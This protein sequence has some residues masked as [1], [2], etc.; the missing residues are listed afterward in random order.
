MVVALKTVDSLLALAVQ[1][2]ESLSVLTVDLVE[3]S[4][5]LLIDILER[6]QEVL[7]P[8]PVMLLQRLNLSPEHVILTDELLLVESVLIRVL[9]DPNRGLRD[10][11]L[12]LAAGLLRVAE[13][14]LVHVH[15]SLQVIHDLNNKRG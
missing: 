12:Q 10:L 4:L 5:V 14:L 6:V 11:N 13:E 2:V 15:I 1:V 7:L 8:P 9:L 3:F